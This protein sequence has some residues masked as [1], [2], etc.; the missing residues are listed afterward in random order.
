MSNL[1][2]TRQNKNKVGE[3]FSRVYRLRSH[4]SRHFLEWEVV[5]K[6][7]SIYMYMI[8]YSRSKRTVVEYKCDWHLKNYYHLYLL[9]SLS[10]ICM[11][12]TV[13]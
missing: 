1:P 3:V 7:L 11:S 9:Y 2:A 13:N 8:M 6:E 10:C 5:T 4:C 12:V